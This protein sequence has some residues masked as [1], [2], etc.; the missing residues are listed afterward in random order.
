M[1]FGMQTDQYLLIHV[2]SLN[3]NDH[4]RHGLHLTSESK[5]KFVQLIFNYIKCKI[6]TD[7]V[8]AI[9]GVRSR[10]LLG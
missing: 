8:P 10:I 6:N 7:K 9:I 4:T 5:E 1:H 3:R 2:L